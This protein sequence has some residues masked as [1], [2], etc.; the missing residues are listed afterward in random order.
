MTERAHVDFCDVV[1]KPNRFLPRH[2][3]RR[4]RHLLAMINES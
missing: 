2:R 1:L 3:H 4:S